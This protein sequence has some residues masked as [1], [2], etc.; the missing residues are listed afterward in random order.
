MTIYN[1]SKYDR[2][3]SEIEKILE[4]NGYPFEESRERLYL[5]SQQLL[6]ALYDEHLEIIFQ[7]VI[8]ERNNPVERVDAN[9]YVV[10]MYMEERVS[11][12]SERKIIRNH[13][14]M[15]FTMHGV[16]HRWLNA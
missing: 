6:R 14:E 5:V 13:L 10:D 7:S 1:Q 8:D 3:P 12:A 15:T 11:A 9:E 2:I 16:T 4:K